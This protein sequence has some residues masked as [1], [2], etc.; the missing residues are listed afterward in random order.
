M[1]LSV[2]AFIESQWLFRA[3]KSSSLET[4]VEFAIR[5]VARN[6]CEWGEIDRIK[7]SPVLVVMS[8]IFNSKSRW[9]T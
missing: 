4:F 8:G 6:L 2:S 7:T 1:F 3:E 5:F 9:R